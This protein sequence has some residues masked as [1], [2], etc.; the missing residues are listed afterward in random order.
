MKQIAKNIRRR[1]LQAGMS[2]DELA[3]RLGVSKTTVSN[4]ER[5][6]TNPSPEIMEKLADVFDVTISYFF[7]RSPDMEDIPAEFIIGG[8][9]F[10]TD[11]YTDDA[12]NINLNILRQGESISLLYSEYSSMYFR[13]CAEVDGA[14]EYFL[15]NKC[16]D[17][18]KEHGMIYACVNGAGADIYYY[19][20]RGVMHVLNGGGKRHR[21]KNTEKLRV[22]GVMC[23]PDW[24]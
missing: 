7:M 10:V 23:E 8:L 19:M 17:L 3:K 20:K 6:V 1:R 14:T 21:L 13:V 2:Q 15:M 24:E 9:D 16:G 12:G 4:Y 18:P 22:I 5:G 11:A